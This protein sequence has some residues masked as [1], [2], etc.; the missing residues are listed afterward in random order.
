ME[1]IGQYITKYVKGKAPK[2]LLE[3]FHEGMQPY[4]S[5]DYLRGK[6]KPEFYSFPSEKT[7]QVDNGEVIVLWDGSNAGEVFISKKGILASTMVMLEF[8]ETE[9]YKSYYSYSFQYL[10]YFLKAK[11]AGS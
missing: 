2:N 8:D 1:N 7:I 3:E 10:E 9:L 11:T 4:L 5:P 6:A